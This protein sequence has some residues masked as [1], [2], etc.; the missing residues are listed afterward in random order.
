MSTTAVVPTV[1]IDVIL[2]E[3]DAAVRAAEQIAAVVASAPSTF[4]DLYFDSGRCRWSSGNGFAVEKVR[5]IADRVA[6]KRL[7]EET[8]LRTFMDAK[9]R[10]E[11]DTQIEKGEFPAFTLAT[12][13]ATIERLHSSRGDMVTR[14]VQECFRRLKPYKTNRADRFAAR[15]IVTNVNGWWSQGGRDTLDDLNRAMHVLRGLPEPDHRQGARSVIDAAKKEPGE[16]LV[17]R[18]PFFDVTIFGNGN[19]HVRMLHEVDVQRLNKVLSIATGG[20]AL[21]GGARRG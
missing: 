13:E 20:A 5:E 18:F 3:R 14:G 21:A 6:W 17:A 11:W 12:A 16:R 8:G 10:D 7:L 1:A 4:P 15:M 19:G 2:A 9:A